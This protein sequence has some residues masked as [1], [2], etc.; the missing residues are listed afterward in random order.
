MT[1]TIEQKQP[2]TQAGTK[3][4]T[5][6]FKTILR[7]VLVG[8]VLLSLAI[9]LVPYGRAHANP[10]VVAEPN[11]DS[12]QTSQLFTQACADCHSNETVWPW[13][14]NVAPLSWLIQKHVDEG[15]AAFNAS[16]MGRPENK[17]DEAAEYVQKGEMP[18]QNYTWLHPE[19]RLSAADKQML[20]DGLL[21]TFGGEA[22]GG[23][24]MVSREG[25]EG[26]EQGE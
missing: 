10:A 23:E 6:R 4:R 17:A 12:A 2:S 26:T 5:L 1:T 16:E 21:A 7:Y 15:R 25:G 24:A 11:W 8:I 14:S 3:S 13:Y 22:E 18:I 19:A 9:Q 20:I